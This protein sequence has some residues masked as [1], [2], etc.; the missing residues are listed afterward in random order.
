MLK[1][2]LSISA[3]GEPDEVSPSAGQLPARLRLLCV[4]P[5]EPSWVSLTL[6]L[7][8][9]GGIEPRFRWVSSAADALS[10][11]RDDTFDCV[12]VAAISADGRSDGFA[13]GATLVKAIRASGCEDPIVLIGP[14]I[15]DNGWVD[16]S[17]EDCE[18][19][20]SARVWDSPALV[21]T[22]HRAIMRA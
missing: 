10:L 8:A 19:L 12:L 5:R 2:E 20:Q 1:D 15:S 9:A 14:H 21:S 7:D 22:I 16:L 18:L 3:E 6:Q 11:L 17:A 4:G 13:D